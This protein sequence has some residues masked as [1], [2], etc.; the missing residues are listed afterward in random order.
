MFK[1][2]FEKNIDERPPKNS[3]TACLKNAAQQFIIQSGKNTEIIAGYPWFGYWGL[4]MFVSLP[5]LTLAATGDAKLCKTILDNATKNIKDG[6]FT[7]EKQHRAFIYASI[8]VPLWY[9]WAVQQYKIFTGNSAEVWKSYGKKIIEILD[10]YRNGKHNV[11]IHDNGLMWQGE[12][13]KALTWMDAIVA[14]KPVTQRAGY[15]VEINALWYN[16]IC[17]AIELANENK[18]K[19]VD[20]QLSPIKTLI[21]ENFYPLFWCEE[22]Q[23]LAD[24]IDENGQNIFTRPNQIFATSLPY[25]PINDDVKEKILKAVKRELLTAKGIRTLAPKNPLYKG[26]Y[27][28]NQTTRDNAHH[29]GSAMPWLLG[30]YVEGNFKLHGKAFVSTAKEIIS[31]FE[32]EMTTYGIASICELY[33]GD[34]PQDAE[35]SISQAWSVAEILRI[36]KMIEEVEKL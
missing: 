6:S 36:M 7:N 15:A 10:T 22:R 23:H 29:Q 26:R 8:D 12:T 17:F 34:P 13:G 1:R 18:N 3:Y 4:D 31:S 16:A 32:E 28:G 35:G 5:G 27:E 30:H 20:K 19:T 14:G 21:E 2:N 9:I 33:D 24:Y 11:Q 25:S